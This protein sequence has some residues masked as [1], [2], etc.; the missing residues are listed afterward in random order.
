MDNVL[1]KQ[2]KKMHTKFG[3]N[4][5]GE[6]CHLSDEEKKFRIVALRE[7]IDEY[8]ESTEL[9]DEYDALID[10]LVFTVGTFER[11]GLRLQDGFDVVMECNMQKNIAGS[12]GNS[13]RGFK[14][15]LVKPDGWVAP[16]KKLQ[17]IIEK[18]KLPNDVLYIRNNTHGNFE[19]SAVFVQSMA[20]LVREAKNWDNMPFTQKEA[21]EMIL[22]KMGRIMFGDFNF[23]DHWVDIA[24]Y[25]TII[26]NE[27][28]SNNE[29]VK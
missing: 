22:H 16:E 26:V 14:R 18:Q 29:N 6:P 19:E 2:V 5:D 11:Q 1:L 7:E 27:L 24:G 20:L 15:D 10:L 3:L 23:S 25:S 17:Q 8:E 4:N 28:K 9:V 13:K 12:N 21:I